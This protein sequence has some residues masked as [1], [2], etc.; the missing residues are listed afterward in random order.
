MMKCEELKE[1]LRQDAVSLV[2]A[3]WHG[4][5][6]DNISSRRRMKIYDEFANKI[7]SASATGKTSQFLEK[8]CEKMD[9]NIIEADAGK[10][11]EVIRDIEAQD[12]D[13]EILDI[14]RSETELVVLLMRED[15]NELKEN[16]KQATLG[17]TK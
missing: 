7:K 10:V 9:S 14:L 1:K 3:V 5:S 12:L 15:N 13:L 4:I 17:A 11:L 2:S 6:F 8:L 16:S